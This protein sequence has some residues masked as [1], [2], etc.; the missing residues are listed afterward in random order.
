[1]PTFGYMAYERPRTEAT[2]FVA[3]GLAIVSW[4]CLPF[5][6]VAALPIASN[7]KKRIESSGGM[8]LGSQMVVAARLIA[9]VNLCV[10]GIVLAVLL[11]NVIN[12]LTTAPD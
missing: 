6:A 8:L 3:L 9:I 2:T 11:L 12:G 10:A 4:A 1:M 7:A 5:L